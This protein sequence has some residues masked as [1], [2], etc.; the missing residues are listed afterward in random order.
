[1]SL[2]DTC[3]SED[4][5]HDSFMDIRKNIHFK[6]N[7]QNY[8]LNEL[9]EINDFR[10]AYEN[11][12]FEF[13]PSKPFT[14]R[15]RGHERYIQPVAF[16]D[17]VIVHSFV[18]NILLPKLCPYLIYDNCASLKGKGYDKQLDRFRTH[19]QRYY[20]HHQTNEGYVLQVDFSKFFDNIRHDK[21]LSM[22]AEKIDD[23]ETV[24]FLAKILK[25]YEVEVSAE[26]YNDCMNGVFNSLEHRKKQIINP[27]KMPKSLGIGNEISQICGLF[28]LY[29][30]DNY[31]KIVKGVKY[32]GRYMDDLI[33]IH[34]D[35]QFLIELLSDIRSISAELGLRISDRKTKITK[36]TKPITFLKVIHILT[37]TGKVIRRRGKEIFQRERVKLKKLADKVNYKYIESQYRSWRGTV[38][39][40]HYKNFRQVARVDRL[41]NELF[42]K[43]FIRGSYAEC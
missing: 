1:M 14:L 27:V 29:R 21:L 28:Y 2:L 3:F 38:E 43:P 42:I 7:V 25:E 13:T 20:F 31:I 36:L 40:K 33:I 19:L 35:K 22:I 32:Y 34:S 23:P 4:A 11:G 37:K 5:L 24:D 9:K 6:Y 30:L 39:R 18:K 8:R 12:T 26:E 41:Y 15:E 16:K 10:T 17:R